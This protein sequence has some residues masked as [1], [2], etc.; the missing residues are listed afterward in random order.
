MTDL[1]YIASPYTHHD[2]KIQ[3][4]RYVDT[5]RFCAESLRDG[6]NVFSPIV[7]WHEA[8]IYHDIPGHYETF[9]EYSQ[10]AILACDCVWVLALDGFDESRGVNEEIAFAR[11]NGKHVVYVYP[12]WAKPEGVM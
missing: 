4:K 7:H 11:E 12:S 3:E 2:K 9:R 6:Y 8:S 1:I 5:R 10:S